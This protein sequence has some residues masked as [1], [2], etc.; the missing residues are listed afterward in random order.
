[1]KRCT[2][3]FRDRHEAGDQLA[4]V[5][6]GHE[7]EDLVIL[8]LPPG[9]APVAAEIARTFQAELG[10]LVLSPDRSGFVVRGHG[11]A[12]PAVE[13]RTVVLA[14]D[15][16]AAPVT[17]EGAIRAM[18]RAGAGRVV[19]AV[20]VA[21]PAVLQ[22]LRREADEVICLVEDAYLVTVRKFYDEVG[23]LN[24]AAQHHSLGLGKLAGGG[25]LA[26]V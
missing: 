6:A 26:A 11:G 18:R 23:P 8:A 5:L 25:L 16:V 2:W 24:G 14:D 12:P 15:G 19:Y 10:T 7:G 3:K 9:G 20:P 4:A 1:V 22:R 17:A 21:S 13:G